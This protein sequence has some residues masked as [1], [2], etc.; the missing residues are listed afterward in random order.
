[1]SKKELIVA[2]RKLADQLGRTPGRE[3][4]AK[5]GITRKMVAQ[6]FSGHREAMKA[7]NLRLSPYGRVLGMDELFADWAGIARELK[8]LPSH[9]EFSKRSRHSSRP[10][11][12]RFRFWSSVPAAMRQYI[13]EHGLTTEWADVM[14][15]IARTEGEAAYQAMLNNGIAARVLT[16]R[17]MYGNF[18]RMGP[19]VC[20]PTNENGV[21][22][23]FGAMA[24]QLGFL[25]LR[26]QIGFPDVEAWR[27][28]GPDRL[29]RVKIEMEY[30]SRNFLT[31]GHNLKG[32]DLII[33]WEHNW[34][35]CPVE[36]IELK[37]LVNK[38]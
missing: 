33:C 34:P 27:I 11:I 25:I 16:D 4:M 22:V 28:I 20:A 14:E 6:H 37:R 24:E 17:P 3:E 1:M 8:R 31:H 38:Q 36:V 12:N 13:E 15:L 29:Q 23:L 7:C 5:H 18:L 9:A 26:V 21:L 32:C 30:Q 2:I 19:M 35:D 10:F